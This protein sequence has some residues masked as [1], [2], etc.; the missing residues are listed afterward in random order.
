MTVNLGHLKGKPSYLIGTRQRCKLHWTT[1]FNFFF[2]GPR[3]SVGELSSHFYPDFRYVYSIFLSGRV[4]KIQRTLFVQNSTLH[5]NET[6]RNLPL[7]CRGGNWLQVH[8]SSVSSNSLPTYLSPLALVLFFH[9]QNILVK[10]FTVFVTDFAEIF[11]E[12]KSKWGP[13]KWIFR[14]ILHAI[15]LYKVNRTCTTSW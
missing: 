14:L 1:K 15:A 3:T 11:W 7:K 2:F 5:T 10:S 9:S 6:G 12:K 8:P 13:K 4:S